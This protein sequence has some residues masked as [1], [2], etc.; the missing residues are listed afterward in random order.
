MRF[1]IVLLL[2][3][4]PSVA[5]AKTPD[6]VTVFRAVKAVVAAEE[7]KDM[8]GVLGATWPEGQLTLRISGAAANRADRK[9]WR[10]VIFGGMGVSYRTTFGNPTIEL[11]GDRAI[12]AV[13]GTTRR[14]YDEEYSGMYATSRNR[15]EMERRGGE[16]R[17]LNWDRTIRWRG[18]DYAW[19]R[20]HPG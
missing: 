14:Y 3:L 5:M 12:V 18:S 2:L 19:H 16:W 7:A 9:R 6:R 15:V 1:L 10:N 11:R 13:S 20:R 17:V 4:A 8:G